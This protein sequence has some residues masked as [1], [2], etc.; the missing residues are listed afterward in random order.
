MKQNNAMKNPIHVNKII[1]AKKGIKYLNKNGKRKMAVPNT[2]KWNV[3]I[4]QGYKEGY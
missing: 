1:E 3:L 2:E 4:E